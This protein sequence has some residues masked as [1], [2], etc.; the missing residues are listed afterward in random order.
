[1]ILNEWEEKEMT[2]YIKDTLKIDVYD[3]PRV[4]SWEMSLGEPRLE[5]RGRFGGGSRDEHEEGIEE[6]ERKYNVVDNHDDDDV[7]LEEGEWDNLKIFMKKKQMIVI[8]SQY[9]QEQM[10][11]I[12]AQY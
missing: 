10:I 6:F 7:E 4:R 5:V 11:V 12:Q 3:C 2:E 8:Q 9:Q 1:M